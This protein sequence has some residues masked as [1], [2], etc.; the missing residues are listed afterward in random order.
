[1]DSDDSKQY[2]R[3]KKGALLLLFV[4]VGAGFVGWTIGRSDNSKPTGSSNTSQ[5]TAADNTDGP[6]VKALVSYTLPDGWR[7]ASCPDAAGSV[8][9]SPQG[10]GAIDCNASPS[11]PV[12]ISVDS[13]NNTDCNQLQ[14]VQNVSKHICISEFINGKKSLKAETKFNEQSTF[15]RDTTIH[16]YYINTGKGVLKV[17][18]VYTNDNSYQSGWEALAKS[19]TVK[20]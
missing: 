19:V 20:N 13:A 1:M 17:E 15:K 16:A 8:F 3:I 12:K 10:A 7:E 14:S 4:I 9:V 11:S 5:P 2:V 6:D 18:Y